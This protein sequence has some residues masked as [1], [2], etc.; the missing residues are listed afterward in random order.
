MNTWKRIDGPA[1]V[2]PS[3]GGGDDTR[4]EHKWYSLYGC[5]VARVEITHSLSATDIMAEWGNDDD[6]EGTRVSVLECSHLYT[7]LPDGEYDDYGYENYEYEFPGLHDY[8]LSDAERAY[9]ALDEMASHDL[10]WAFCGPDE[11]AVEVYARAPGLLDWDTAMKA[12]DPL[13]ITV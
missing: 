5:G 10:S 3:E 2:S 9:S 7:V 4:G 11:K 12:E 8:E 13:D 6:D 1:K